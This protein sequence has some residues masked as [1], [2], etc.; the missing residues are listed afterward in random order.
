MSRSQY[1]H[2]AAANTDVL[3]SS[4]LANLGPGLYEVWGVS[5]AITNGLTVTVQG[6]VVALDGPLLSVRDGTL[7]A[8]PVNEILPYVVMY[9]GATGTQP[10]IAISGAGTWQLA[11]R[12][13][14]AR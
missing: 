6:G 7:P 11:I 10:T 14:P 9:R 1:F 3:A 12:F 8:V 2:G 4:S 5:S 13:T